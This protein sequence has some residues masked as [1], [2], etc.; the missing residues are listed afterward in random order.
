MA[1]LLGTSPTQRPHAALLG[2]AALQRIGWASEQLDRYIGASA[3]RRSDKVGDVRGRKRLEDADPQHPGRHDR[4][5]IGL[6][7]VARQE[8]AAGDLEEPAAGT[9]RPRR[10]SRSFT[11]ISVS[12]F[13]TAADSAGCDT[14]TLAAPLVKLPVSATATTWRI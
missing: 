11:P 12:S 1:S 13:A 5:K 8:N 7:A 2:E 10:R 9:A 14:V 4:P 3:P 6:D